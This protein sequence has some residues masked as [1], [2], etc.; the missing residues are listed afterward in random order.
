[1]PAGNP[2]PGEGFRGR[3]R[4]AEDARFLFLGPRV[5]THGFSWL[6]L[7]AG[8]T[9]GER[10]KD[11]LNKANARCE[12]IVL[13]ASPERFPPLNA[14]QRFAKGRR[15]F[16]RGRDRVFLGAVLARER[17]AAIMAKASMT[18]ET[19]VV[20]SPWSTPP[21]RAMP[22]MPGAGFVVIKTELVLGRFEAVLDGP[23]MA[24]H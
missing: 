2:R 4:Q 19:W 12:A 21:C 6:C 10:W 13:L 11:A 8:R 9:A 24:F 18:N 16:G 3:W 17:M 1:V 22:A 23:A 5:P 20:A 7:T 15:C 14:S